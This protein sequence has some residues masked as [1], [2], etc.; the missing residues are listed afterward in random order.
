V[1]APVPSPGMYLEGQEELTG[2]VRAALDELLDEF[3]R[4][5][6][7]VGPRDDGTWYARHRV[8]HDRPRISAPTLEELAGKLREVGR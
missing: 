1:V 2:P 3:G 5:W 4:Q 8:D 6:W 7:I